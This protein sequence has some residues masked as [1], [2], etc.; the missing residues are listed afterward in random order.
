MCR[1]ST[2]IS[3]SPLHAGLFSPLLSRCGKLSIAPLCVLPKESEVR[4]RKGGREGQLE[5][6]IITCREGERREERQRH[7]RR[8]NFESQFVFAQ[9]L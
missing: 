4:G 3:P 8:R 6:D 5:M 9:Q 2:M 7:L 1:R